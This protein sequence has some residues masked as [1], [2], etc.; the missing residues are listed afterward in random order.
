MGVCITVMCTAW[1]YLHCTKA[2]REK[3]AKQICHKLFALQEPFMSAMVF[4]RPLC[5]QAMFSQ[6]SESADHLLSKKWR[7]QV[8]PPPPLVRAN[9]ESNFKGHL[10]EEEEEELPLL[11]LLELL[12]LELA[13]AGPEAAYSLMTS[14]HRRHVSSHRKWG[15]AVRST[16]LYSASIPCLQTAIKPA[17]LVLCT[18][19]LRWRGIL[20]PGKWNDF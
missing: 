13:E 17:R 14:W 1:Y 16:P 20:N 12:L 6:Q 18:L 5:C 8:P 7:L 19:V 10:E 11:L 3:G 9:L 15:S 4:E 2:L